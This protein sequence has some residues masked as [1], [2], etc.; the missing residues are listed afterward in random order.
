MIDI[1]DL[2]KSYKL[3]RV[4]RLVNSYELIRKK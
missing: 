4:K 1:Y 3:L 2:V